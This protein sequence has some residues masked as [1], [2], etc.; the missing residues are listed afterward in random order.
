ME[1]LS[2]EQLNTLPKDTLVEMV[3]S[4]SN[5]IKELNKKMDLMLEQMAIMNNARFGRKTEKI[6]VLDEQLSFFN[7]IEAC[8][9]ES[10]PEEDVTVIVPSY[11]RKKS[12]GKRNDDLSGFPVK[13]VIHEI[14]EDEL[15]I[16]FP[17]GY[18]HLP[19]E[20]Y[21]KLNFIPA[22]Y[23][24]LEHH[25][26]VYKSKDDE[27]IVKAPHP[28]DMLEKSIATPSLVSAILNA[29]YTNA[30][31][32]YRIEKDFERNDIHISRQ[33]MSNWVITA[34]ERYL[35]LVYDK[36]KKE[37]LN[38]RIVHADE[39]PLLVA[40]D[41][42]EGMHKSYMW[43]YRSGSNCAAND[44]VIYDYQKN[45]KQS[46][47]LEFLNGYS[48][49]LVTDG[50]EVYH[51]IERKKTEEIQVAGCW[52][53]AKRKFS[54]VKKAGKSPA[55]EERL[56]EKIIAKISRIFHEDNKLDMLP[57]EE[58]LL[59]R[60]GKIKKLVDEFFVFL[61]SEE[62]NVL[63]EG[64]TGKGIRYCLNQEQYLR[65]FIDNPEIPMDNNAAEL[66]IRSFTIGR[67]N[68]RIID[69]INGAE[70]SA[71][72]YSIVE[73]AKANNLKIYDYFCHLLTEIPK[74]M[75]DTNL[76]FLDELLPWS[77][78]L[79]EEIHKKKK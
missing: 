38:S 71:M 42:R 32:L 66:A 30:L 61:K 53:H 10:H 27:R 49:V 78:E 62:P 26:C 79:P 55:C 20:T 77:K 41:G 17:N 19:D 69:T 1:N 60:Q 46:A 39:T 76:N 15:N 18:T 34:T 33:T 29:K 14:P 58:R 12:A 24:V 28:A 47:P 3:L 48:G 2:R 37:L 11:K 65:R 56:S 40:K 25:R 9:D 4:L 68:W 64:E 73:T 35:S 13:I 51:G 45:R 7:E 8:A 43:V 54:N 6:A 23:E 16:L 50:Y 36:M 59:K 44:V 52:V 70:A 31:P 67:N 74:H 72:L 5:Q 63:S 57:P 75:N 22:S 21:T